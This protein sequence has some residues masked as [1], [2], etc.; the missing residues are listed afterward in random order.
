MEAA[1]LH[2][3][4]PAFR[5]A[6]VRAQ[7]R[8]RQ[9]LAA[10]PGTWAVGCS[11]G[12]DSSAMLALCV[13]AGWRGP[14]FHFRYRQDYDRGSWEMAARLADRYGLE[15]DCVE[16]ASE[17]DAF[18]RAGHFFATPTTPEERA[19]ASWWLRTHKRQIA[20]HQSAR[21][22]AGVF[23]GMRRDESRVRATTLR[24]KGW[25]YQTQERPGWTCCPLFDWSGRDVWSS[26]AAE[27]LPY[28]A[29]YD[30]AEDRVLER[31]EDCWLGVDIWRW[32]MATEMQ[33]R[34]P[35]QWRNLVARYPELSKQI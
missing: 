2:A 3:K 24:K 22:W 20:E 5:R 14:V 26:I 4:L 29:R 16:V 35:E 15:F 31:S 17:F 1:R 13:A 27:G 33:R 10:A 7:D 28:L 12:K 34:N 30:A 32:G 25:L 19:A 23:I 21:G 11:G 9:A 8:V 18:E 6:V